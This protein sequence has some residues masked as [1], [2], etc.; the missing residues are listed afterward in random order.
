MPIL[1][2][3]IKMKKIILVVLISFLAL[4]GCKKNQLG[5]KSTISGVIKHHSKLI[6]NAT[7]FIKFKSKEFP[8]PDTTAYDDKVKADASGS[9]TIK[10]YKGDYYLFAV[11]YDYSIP[12]PYRVV[13]GS[14]VNIRNKEKVT[15]DL[16]V[17]E[18]D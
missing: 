7:V 11:G 12:A 15:I 14:P 18:G 4:S 5:G 9:Y 16:A 8:G 3:V 17:T 6:A 2:V 13:G 1:T 10:C